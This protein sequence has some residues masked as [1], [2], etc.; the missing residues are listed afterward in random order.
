MLGALRNN[1]LPFKTMGAIIPTDIPSADNIAH[2]RAAPI[3]RI[4]TRY[5]TLAIPQPM[6]STIR[7]KQWFPFNTLF[8]Q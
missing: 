6:D 3:F 4:Q 2:E 5:N 1:P 7:D 8:E